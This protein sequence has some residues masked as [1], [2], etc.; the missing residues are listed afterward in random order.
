MC[1]KIRAYQWHSP[2]AF[3]LSYNSNT[4]DDPYFDGVAV[5]HGQRPRQ[6]I[7][8]FAAGTPENATNLGSSAICPC[9]RGG[10]R[11]YHPPLF[12]GEDYFCESGYINPG[13]YDRDAINQLHYN[14]TLWDGEDCHHT[15]TCCSLHNPPYF[16]KTLSDITDDDLEVRSC[17]F[18]SP[19][20]IE[21]VELYV[22]P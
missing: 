14:D 9:D 6:H 22:K 16:T 19:V 20:A 13:Y 1:G 15:S 10:G 3:T 2:A 21:L 11:F 4:P 17:T 8:T 12:V 5:L 7:W 18:G